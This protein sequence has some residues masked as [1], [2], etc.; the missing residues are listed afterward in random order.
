MFIMWTAVILVMKL[1]IQQF[2]SVKIFKLYRDLTNIIVVYIMNNEN[3]CFN[4]MFEDSAQSCMNL[5][6]RVNDRE[7][8]EINSS[9]YPKMAQICNFLFNKLLNT[10]SHLNDCYLSSVISGLV[11][12]LLE[13]ETNWLGFSW[14]YVTINQKYQ[15]NAFAIVLSEACFKF[16]K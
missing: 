7:L 16:L 1:Y 9:I 13:F 2:Q 4:N 15:G 8:Q 10:T 12:K 11:P 5:F 14:F 6:A 3:G